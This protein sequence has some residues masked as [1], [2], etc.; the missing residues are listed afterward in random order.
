MV[1]T[2]KLREYRLRVMMGILDWEGEIGNA[3]VRHLFDLQAVQA[4]RL[5]GEFRMLMGDRLL[6]DGKAKTLKLVAPKIPCSDMTL[7]QYIR[8]VHRVD[9]PAGC[10]VDARVDLT[11]IRPVVF[12]VLRKAAIKQVGVTVDYA[13]MSNTSFAKRVIFP[14]VIVQAGRR[15]HVRAWC[16]NHHDFRDF[17]LGRIKSAKLTDQVAPHPATADQ[18]WYQKV[19]IRLVPHR[20]LTVEQKMVVRNEYFHGTMG[21]KLS[22]SA[23]LVQY[24]VQ[25]LRAATDPSRETPPEY[26]IEVANVDDLP[27]WPGP[28]GV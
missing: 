24:V 12:A 23:C 3:R 8:E 25:D 28:T 27:L 17:T 1:N 2:T 14:H 13:S 9:D 4:S 7:E 26:Q 5:L 11:D 15:W 18:E 21:R 10:I 16:D 6:E 19:Q 22:I 20:D